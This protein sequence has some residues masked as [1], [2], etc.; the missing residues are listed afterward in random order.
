MVEATT[1]LVMASL[2]ILILG[3]ASGR[4]SK[5]SNMLRNHPLMRE[6]PVSSFCHC[7]IL[8]VKKCACVLVYNIP[9]SGSVQEKLN[10]KVRRNLES[11]IKVKERCLDICAPPGQGAAPVCGSRKIK[12]YPSPSQS[13]DSFRV[14]CLI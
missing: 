11:I 3:V 7:D 10:F 9:S 5:G 6:I 4:H 14:P 12:V 8:G 2:E 13:K 1:C